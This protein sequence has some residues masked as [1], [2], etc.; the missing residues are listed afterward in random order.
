LSIEAQTTLASICR[1]FVVQ[2][3]VY[4]KL[5]NT[6]TKLGSPTRTNPQRFDKTCQDVV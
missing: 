1:G 4:N 5:Y 2:L 3:D 6:S